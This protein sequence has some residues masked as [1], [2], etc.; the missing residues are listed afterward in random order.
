MALILL[1]RETL[2]VSLFFILFVFFVFFYHLV[3]IFIVINDIILIQ[4]KG[5]NMLSTEKNNDI[6]NQNV[7]KKSNSFLYWGAVVV[8]LLT[9]FSFLYFA[10]NNQQKVKNMSDTFLSEIATGLSDK[11]ALLVED[12]SLSLTAFANYTSV[13]LDNNDDIYYFLNTAKDNTQF[14]DIFISF[15]GEQPINSE[16]ESLNIEMSEVFGVA[17]EGEV[18]IFSPINDDDGTEYLLFGIPVYSDGERIAELYGV[19]YLDNFSEVLDLKSFGGEA[20]YHLCEVDGT[21]IYLSGSDDNLFQDGDM[22]SFIGSLDIYNGHTTQS[23]RT[24][25]EAGKSVILNY[26]INSQD[27]SAV[28]V[29]VPGTDWCVVSIVLADVN[30][31]MLQQISD[32]TILFLIFLVVI[33]GLY[34]VINLVLARRTRRALINSLESSQRLTDSLQTTIETDSLTGAYSRATAAQ[35]ITETINEGRRLGDTHALAILDVDNFKGVNDTYG[36]QTG[37]IYLKAL[38]LAIRAGLRSGDILGRLGGDEFIML[39]N[40]VN[41]PEASKRVIERIFDNVKNIEIDDVSLDNVSVSAGVVMINGEK[42]SYDELSHMADT[43]LYDAKR[44]GKN[45]CRFYN[46]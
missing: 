2:V 5:R 8:A 23:I 9:V 32:D 35:K 34:F 39:L 43:A 21:P 26:M 14:D 46:E 24:D 20:F 44:D 30:L 7:N 22:Y 37:D 45:I 15:E 6:N 27:R 10:N 25:M 4:R 42:H 17:T 3:L 28:M 33:F 16:K 18:K 38:V 31:D 1:P 36:H 41:T 13:F 19:Y 29:R 40:N 12:S 11:I